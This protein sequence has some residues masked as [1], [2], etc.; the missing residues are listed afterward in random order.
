MGAKVEDGPRLIKMIPMGSL[1]I[2]AA[3]NLS[4]LFKSGPFNLVQYCR[5]F[6]APRK[7]YKVI[8]LSLKCSFFPPNIF[9]GVK[10]AII[11]SFVCQYLSF[12]KYKFCFI[13]YKDNR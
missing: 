6:D 13:A 5:L 1:S 8:N 12:F 7:A 9:F 11:S 4:P 2:T 10:V 3:I